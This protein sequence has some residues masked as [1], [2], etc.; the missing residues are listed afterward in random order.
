ARSGGV[1]WLRRTVPEPTSRR[2][3][4]AAA[5]AMRTERPDEVNAFIVISL[6]CELSFYQYVKLTVSRARPLTIP[7]LCLHLNFSPEPAQPAL[8]A[9]QRSD[10]E[11]MR[12]SASP[13]VFPA[14][15]HSTARPGSLERAPFSNLSPGQPSRRERDRTKDMSIWGAS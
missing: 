6:S 11:L 8:P 12:C 1:S 9:A 7:W 5:K 13:L 2:E 3:V 15:L 4:N 14:A 10:G